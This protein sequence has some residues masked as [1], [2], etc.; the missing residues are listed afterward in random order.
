MKSDAEQPAG[1]LQDSSTGPATPTPNYVV[2]PEHA[3]IVEPRRGLGWLG[4]VITLAILLGASGWLALNHDLASDWVATRGYQAPNNIQQMADATSMT[5]YARRLF[6][7]NK[8]AVEGRNAFNKECSNA[9]DQ[10]SVLGCYTGNR[11]GIYIYNV[12]DARL[13]GIQQVTAA[14]EMLHQ[15]YDR[16]SDSE[17]AEI[18]TLL[19]D[20][21]KTVTDPELLSKM[22]AYKKS[23][24]H[25][26][27][28]EYHSIFGTEV[29]KLPAPL[30]DYY[31]K[32]FTDRGKVI[33]LHD[34]YQ[35]VFTE[36]TNQIANYDKQLDSLKKQIEQDKVSI[37][38]QE[39]DLKLRRA[40]MD[41]WLDANNI[42]AYNEAVPS[43][44]ADV[45]RYKTTV[46]ST[47]AHI[48]EYNRLIDARNNIAVEEQQL[49]QALDSHA[50]T[51]SQQ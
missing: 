47:N 39:A 45:S 31:K 50:A 5:P 44:N 6:Y 40:Q 26:L 35:A 3:P 12:T 28:N 15:A 41:A 49:Q 20:Y 21:A 36:R 1:P 33:A 42:S 46:S 7:V 11:Q 9:S 51:A 48:D 32:Y 30:E 2:E 14:H 22:D 18:D 24:P 13:D 19:V 38:S 37:S 34:K 8:P 29:A 16:L 23:E 4:P 25:D 43:F 10:V 27:V 17:R